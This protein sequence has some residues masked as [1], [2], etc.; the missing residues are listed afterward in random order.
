MGAHVSASPPGDPAG[1]AAPSL[2]RNRDFTYLW[3]GQVSSG[4]GSRV[5]SVA[6]PLLVLSTWGSPSR[7]GLVGFA[8]LVPIPTLGLLAG[9]FLDRIDRR[10]AML[11]CE[12]VRV[13][14]LASVVVVMVMGDLSF[15]LL[16][17]V[18]L[19]DGAGTVTFAVAERAALIRVVSPEQL[20][21]AVS[22]NQVRSYTADVVGRPLGGFLFGL[23]ASLPFVADCISYAVSAVGV[24]LIRTPLQ[25]DLAGRRHDASLRHE[26]AAGFHW[27]FS[28]PLLRVTVL[29]VAGSDFAIAALYLVVIVAA[30]RDGASPT[31]LGIALA[32]AGGGGVLGALLAPLLTR[33]VSARVVIIG[34]QCATALLTPLLAF[35]SAPIL[36]G[37]IL[38]AIFSV[39]PLWNAIVVAYRTSI[40]PD[41][42]QAR[43]QSI[44][45]VLSS[46]AAPL[47]PLVAGFGIEWLGARPTILAIS[48][49]AAVAAI[50]AVASPAVRKAA[51]V[52]TDQ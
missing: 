52:V 22:L 8:Q 31:S 34:A 11:W 46:S 15:P 19:I 1:R 9:G 4:L 48:S 35:S 36:D 12:I 20:S 45:V 33:H 50:V 25:G 40:T 51:F 26:I 7:A 3:L 32:L 47:G 18:A 21:Q 37:L 5:S 29:L 10:R 42:L 23:S 14:A 28:R 13:L 16:L 41:N 24:A 43:V 44:H 39:W 49:V 38:G 27:L 17:G 2:S 6:L 30:E